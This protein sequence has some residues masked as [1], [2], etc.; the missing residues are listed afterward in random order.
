M[1]LLLRLVE[2]VAAGPLDDGQIVHGTPLVFV[3]LEHHRGEVHRREH[4][5]EARGEVFLLLQIAAEREHGDVDGERERRR[6]A[7]DVLVVA[8]GVADFRHVREARVGERHDEGAHRVA[9]G[10][11]DVAE[12]RRIEFIDTLLAVRVARGVH[13]LEHERMAAYRALAEDDERARED[14]GAFHRDGDWHHL[15]VAAEI[16]ARA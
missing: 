14:V 10:E 3:V 4:V 2:L 9:D 11:A 7:H 6:E 12:Q 13:F 15:V 1:Q 8:L 16:V 5:A